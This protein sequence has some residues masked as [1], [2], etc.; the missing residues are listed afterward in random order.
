MIVLLLG[1]TLGTFEAESEY[2]EGELLVAFDGVL[3]E[4]ERRRLIEEYG[5]E[6]IE[7][8]DGIGVSWLSLR[9]EKVSRSLKRLQSDARFRFAEPNYIAHTTGRP[10][11]PRLNE[12]WG[13]NQI[14]VF[15]AWDHGMGEGIIV[16][17]LDTGV[18][19]GGHDG[20]HDLQTGRDFVYGG[21]MYDAY[22]HGTHVSGTIAQ[23]TDNGVGVA[24]V[25]PGVTLLPVKVLGDSGSGSLYGIAQG[26]IWAADEGASVINMSI[27]F[28]GGSQSVQEAVQYANNKGVVVVAAAGNEDTSQLNYPAAYSEVISVGATTSTDRLASFT[29]WGQGLDLVAPGV[30]ILQEVPSWYYSAWSGTSMATPHVAAVAALVMA[31][32]ISDP[33]VVRQILQESATDLGDAGYDIWYGYG[34]LNAEAAVDLAREYA[35]ETPEEPE[36]E[37]PEEEEPEE[38]EQTGPDETPPQILNADWGSQST[39]QMYVSWDT[40]EDAT[41]DI[42]FAEWGWYIE[43]ELSMEHD[44]DFT[45][46]S[47]YHYEFWISSEDASGNIAWSGPHTVHVQ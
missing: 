19:S 32:G 36:E 40:D 29:N 18:Q 33:E 12:Q 3:T 17:V 13:L 39:G 24:G 7:H 34:L 35:G 23:K 8:A 2:V 22:G 15:N 41:S 5:F 27:G 10:D 20:I 45:V 26:I 9:D 14:S 30:D 6:E 31:Q 4:H 25:A 46:S 21:S 44:R 43:P 37:E 42:W 38:E 47:D 11:D 28:W 16:A 1:C